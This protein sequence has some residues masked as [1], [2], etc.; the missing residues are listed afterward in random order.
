[1]PLDRTFIQAFDKRVASE[2]EPAA[3]LS[4]AEPIAPPAR[5]RR[6][7]LKARPPAPE[8]K[9]RRA[10]PEPVRASAPATRKKSPPPVAARA[11]RDAKRRKV[12]RLDPPE[13][14]LAPTAGRPAETPLPDSREAGP[15]IAASAAAPEP[16]SP[17][18]SATG[19]DGLSWFTRSLSAARAPLSSL[20]PSENLRQLVDPAW[21]VE[22]VDWPEVCRRWHDQSGDQLDRVAHE[23]T[24]ARQHRVIAVTGIRRSEGRTTLALCLAR[25]LAGTGTS[26]ALVDADFSR[27]ALAQRLGLSPTCGW[28]EHLAGQVPLAEALVEAVSD[29]LTLLPLRG[30]VAPGAS[31]WNRHRIDED[32]AALRERYEVVVIDAAPLPAGVGDQTSPDHWTQVDLALLVRDCRQGAAAELD[33]AAWRLRSAGVQVW[34]VVENYVRNQCA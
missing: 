18:T 26:V 22:H 24:A 15:A 25:V 13:D 1:M 4:A 5:R 16:P 9:Q 14:V 7:K 2:P 23:L 30:P 8:S 32:L 17:P 10:K 20:A 27:P 3:P 29:R 31:A 12:Y 34:G 33:T 19:G 21:Q 11:A 28:S 6:R